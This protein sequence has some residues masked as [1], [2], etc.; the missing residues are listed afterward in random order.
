MFNF[1]RVA[2]GTNSTSTALDWWPMSNHDVAHTSY[3]SST[4]PA[5]NSTIWIYSIKGEWPSSAISN[6]FVY[7]AGGDNVYA[8]DASTGTLMWNYTARIPS[9]P[10]EN[11]GVV[12][13]GSDNECVYTLNATTGRLIWNYN[14]TGLQDSPNV[15]SGPTYGDTAISS[16]TILDGVVYVCSGD[17]NVFAL[18]AT[19]GTLLW[20]YLAVGGSSSP[21][22]SNG[23]IYFSSMVEGSYG[24]VYALDAATGKL[25]WNFAP[26]FQTIQ[27]IRFLGSPAVAYGVVYGGHRTRFTL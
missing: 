1:T 19:T 3:S 24:K 12:Y 25:L 18:N 21:A 13:F 2:S 20:D 23:I 11:N 22:V 6:G 5:T 15:L 27:G 17:G 7:V 9:T 8:L 16:P 26:E 4:G 10:T 14:S